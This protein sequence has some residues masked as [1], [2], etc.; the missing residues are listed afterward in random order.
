MAASKW[1]PQ[2]LVAF[3]EAVWSATT[4]TAAG[5]MAV[6]RA[7]EALD[8]EIAAIVCVDRVVAVVGYPGG[9]VPVRELTRITAEGA[10]HELT[11][12]D[13]GVCRMATVSLD[14]P[15]GATFIVARAGPDADLRQLADRWQR[16]VIL[17]PRHAALAA[18]VL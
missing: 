7:A 4:E 5:R 2:Q 17:E 12:P 13:V 3:L 11:V 8:A 1:F 15:P 16:E 18:G 14:Y 10:H 6:E 9:A